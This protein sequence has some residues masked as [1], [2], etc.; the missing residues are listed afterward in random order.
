M[1]NSGNSNFECSQAWKFRFSGEIGEACFGSIEFDDEGSVVLLSVLEG[2]CGFNVLRTLGI[3]LVRHFPG[4][5]YSFVGNAEI[6]VVKE[7]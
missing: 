5:G 6:K 7:L 3:D 1:K 4:K 2:R